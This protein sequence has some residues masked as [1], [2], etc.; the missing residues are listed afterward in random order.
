MIPKGRVLDE[1]SILEKEFYNRTKKLHFEKLK[2]EVIDFHRNTINCITRETNQIPE[3]VLSFNDL[4]VKCNGPNYLLLLR[5][6]ESIFQS[7][8]EIV[9][10]KIKL[11]LPDG[12]CENILL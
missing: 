10:E 6:Y 4:L 12:F 9:L 2:E 5:F 11:E 3:R 8:K 7:A 1:M